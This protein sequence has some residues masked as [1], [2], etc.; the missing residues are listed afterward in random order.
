MNISRSQLDS[1][2]R[3]YKE[4]SGKIRKDSEKE[5]PRGAGTDSISLSAEALELMN[6]VKSAGADQDVR[7]E[8][9]AALREKIN[10]GTYNIDGEL[11][12]EKL[13]EEHF[14]DLFV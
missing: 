10:S 1:Y 14:G 9:I 8:K 3:I 6:A 13:L 2:I 7:E 12:A 11:V 5:K 4:Q